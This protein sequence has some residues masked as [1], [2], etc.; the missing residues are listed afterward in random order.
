[1]HCSCFTM[2]HSSH[3]SELI[4]TPPLH[5]ASSVLSHF[6]PW[7][8]SNLVPSYCTS[9]AKVANHCRSLR[10]SPCHIHFFP[11]LLR[12]ILR[13]H[14]DCDRVARV[15]N[16]NA[17]S[18]P[19]VASAFSTFSPVEAPVRPCRNCIKIHHPNSYGAD[20]NLLVTAIL[21]MNGTYK[22]PLNSR[23]PHGSS[24]GWPLHW[25]TCVRISICRHRYY[26]APDTLK[27]LPTSMYALQPKDDA[28]R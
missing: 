23:Q 24:C 20:L 4:S 26:R 9:T 6:T 13:V 16:P 2:F 3:Q 12:Q 17:K 18:C 1:M 19:R 22:P 7:T 25:L 8:T 27:S 5:S 21:V 15:S 10:R 28:D 14:Q 11:C